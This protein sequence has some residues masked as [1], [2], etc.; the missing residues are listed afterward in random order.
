M[1]LDQMRRKAEFGKQWQEQ[2]IQKA[3]FGF[4]EIEN[5]KALIEKES[6]EQRRKRR[7][8]SVRNMIEFG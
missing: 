2:M 8:I 7:E 1:L 5:Q 3:D 4:R 6:F